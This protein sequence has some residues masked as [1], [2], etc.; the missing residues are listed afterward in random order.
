MET[1]FHDVDAKLFPFV[2][3]FL[4]HDSGDLIKKIDVPGPG[5]IAV[6]GLGPRR[7]DVFIRYADGTSTFMSADDVL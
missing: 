2:V 6:P 1:A 5:G 7:I 3:S 4:D